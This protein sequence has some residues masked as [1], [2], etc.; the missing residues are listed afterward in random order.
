MIFTWYSLSSFNW[1][2]IPV[3][4]RCWVFW[5]I[6][7]PTE[8]YRENIC[9]SIF[10]VVGIWV[11]AYFFLGNNWGFEAYKF[12]DSDEGLP[13]VNTIEKIYLGLLVTVFALAIISL[14]RLSHFRTEFRKVFDPRNGLTIF[15]IIFLFWNL[16]LCIPVNRLKWYGIE[17]LEETDAETLDDMYGDDCKCEF[18]CAFKCTCCQFKCSCRW[19]ENITLKEHKAFQDLRKVSKPGI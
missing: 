8:S 15:Q 2:S 18:K 10:L 3:E 11:S 19:N 9:L 6:R 13:C 1:N 12:V 17:P 14:F 7:S 4:A 5:A 16:Y